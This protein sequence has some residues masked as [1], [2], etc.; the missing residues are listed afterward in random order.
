MIISYFLTGSYNDADND[1]ELTIRKS[2]HSEDVND[3]Q[4][5]AKLEDVSS[6]DHLIK[7][8]E[9]PSFNLCLSDIEDFIRDNSIR[10]YGKNRTSSNTDENIDQL[11]QSFIFNYKQKEM[12]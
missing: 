5:Y 9:Q 4:Y 2:L 7:E 12:L 1:F 10:F 3:I 8:T 6:S 11:L